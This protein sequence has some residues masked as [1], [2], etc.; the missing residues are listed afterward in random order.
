MH[1]LAAVEES[2]AALEK[3]LAMPEGVLVRTLEHY[4]RCAERGEDPLFHKAAKWL[5]PL[6]TPPYAALD[7][8]TQRSLFGVFTLGGLAVADHGRGAERRGRGR[9]GALRGRPLH[10]GSDPRGP[11]LRERALDR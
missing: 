6:S 2:F 10:G 7:C 5:R 3:A 9:A 8:S 11:Q 1:K 4:N